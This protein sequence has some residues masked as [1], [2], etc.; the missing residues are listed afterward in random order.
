M[1]KQIVLLPVFVKVRRD[2]LIVLYSMLSRH[3]LT[4]QKDK[5]IAAFKEINQ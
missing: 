5:L 2:D 1:S 3:C 4:K